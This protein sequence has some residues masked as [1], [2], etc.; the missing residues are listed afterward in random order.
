M[1]RSVGLTPKGFNRMLDC[2]TVFYG[3]KALLWGLPLSIL[4]SWLLFTS[5]SSGFRFGFALPWESYIIAVVGVF[6]LVGLSMLYARSKL[7]NLNIAETLK[8][9]NW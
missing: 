7:K 5:M 6:L 4:L 2:E 1:L 3:V 8:N 9:E